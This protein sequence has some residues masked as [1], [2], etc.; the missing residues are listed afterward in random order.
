MKTQII[1]HAEEGKILTN[2]DICGKI[3]YL[4]ESASPDDFHEIS[5][6][7]YEKILAERESKETE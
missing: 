7:E 2:G 4:P 3:I 1:L 6:E 5:I